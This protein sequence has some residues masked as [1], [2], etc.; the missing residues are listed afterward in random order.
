MKRQTRLIFIALAAL[1]LIEL[2][3][4]CANPIGSRT[5]GKANQPPA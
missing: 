5:P 4:A 3:A 1:L 2:L